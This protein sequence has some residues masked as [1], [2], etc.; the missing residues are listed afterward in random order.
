MPFFELSGLHIFWSVWLLVAAIIGSIICIEHKEYGWA[1]FII[2]LWLAQVFFSPLR[3]TTPEPNPE[4]S[5]NQLL[6]A[7]EVRERIYVPSARDR[8]ERLN[9]QLEQNWKEINE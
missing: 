1:A 6:Q 4:A 7:E 2:A 8:E 9:Q 3:Y 5:W